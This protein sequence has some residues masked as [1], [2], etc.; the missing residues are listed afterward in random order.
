MGTCLELINERT[1]LYIKIYDL[2]VVHGYTEKFSMEYVALE[3]A[4]SLL[5]IRYA[6]IQKEIIDRFPE[7]FLE[8]KLS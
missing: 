4:I 1:K 5:R 2:V 6:Q 3:T 7:F 8:N